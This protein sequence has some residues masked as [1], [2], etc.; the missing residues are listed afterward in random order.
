MRV[1]TPRCGA[2]RRS[3]AGAICAPRKTAR[4]V[5]RELQP[6]GAQMARRGATRRSGAA[7]PRR[8]ASAHTHTR[9]SEILL[10]VSFMSRKKRTCA[11]Q[12]VCTLTVVFPRQWECGCGSRGS[13]AVPP[14]LVRHYACRG[15]AQVWRGCISCWRGC[16]SKSFDSHNCST[17][18]RREY[19]RRWLGVLKNALERVDH[20]K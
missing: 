18:W 20:L 15:V 1:C 5:A 13:V 4:A 14:Q 11:L 10:K 16:T 9:I 6:R 19:R 12:S 7:A 2:T 8:S 3:C 17:R